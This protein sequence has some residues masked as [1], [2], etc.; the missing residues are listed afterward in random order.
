HHTR[1]NNPLCTATTT[2]TPL[3]PTP[4]IWKAAT[5]KARMRI[6]LVDNHGP[7]TI[8]ICRLIATVVGS[9]PTILTNDDKHWD[10]IDTNTFDALII[11]P[12]PGHPQNPH[13][14]G[15]TLNLLNHTH[16]PVLGLGLGHLT[17]AHLAGAHVDLAPTPRYG[18]LSHH[19][20]TDHRLFTGLPHHFSA[21]RHHSLAVHEPLP[22]TLR[23]TAWAEDNVVM[24]LEHRNLPRWGLQFHP[25]SVAGEHGNALLTAFFDHIRPR[26]T[27]PPATPRTTPPPTNPTPTATP[28]HPPGRPAP[29]PKD[30]HASPSREHPPAKYSPTGTPNEPPTY[31]T[32][33][34]P[35]AKNPEPSSRPWTNACPIR[36]T[37]TCPSTSPAD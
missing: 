28:T 23:A 32:P 12:G 3:H 35:K 21:V 36:S 37:P 17:I 1:G 14:L 34:A 5:R 9:T 15:H 10:H 8:N 22:T 30:Q 4:I 24:G 16:L 18:H 27:T 11:S 26:A 29:A 33:T 19:H 25:E 7:Y 13:D 31:T 2:P 20:H 6:L